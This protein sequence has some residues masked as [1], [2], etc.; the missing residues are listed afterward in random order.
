MEEAARRQGTL[1]G[2]IS[3]FTSPDSAMSAVVQSWISSAVVRSRAA[4]QS[5]HNQRR[6]CL[7]AAR[8]YNRH[9]YVRTL[10]SDLACRVGLL[11]RV[12][13][14]LFVFLGRC[15]YPL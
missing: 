1:P 11:H 9:S 14:Y 2:G 6:H 15:L 13:C 7:A 3:L 8:D 5:T 4:F 12:R 10:D